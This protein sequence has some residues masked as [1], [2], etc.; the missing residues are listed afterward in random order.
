VFL[1]LIII[2]AREYKLRFAEANFFSC[3][4]LFLYPCRGCNDFSQKFATQ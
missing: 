4:I 2:A 3:F 1:N